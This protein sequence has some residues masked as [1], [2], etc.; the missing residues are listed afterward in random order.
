MAYTPTRFA[1][2][3]AIPS[4][5]TN[6]VTFVSP[7]IVKQMSFTNITGGTLSFSM[8]LVPSGAQ[9][10]NNSNKLF[11]DYSLPANST[12]NI[13]FS[14]VCNTGESLYAVANVPN[15]INVVISGITAA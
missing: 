12:T 15:S 8:Y 2:P 7:V 11:G 14:L 9:V 10:G 3:Q 4:V 1:G 6:L 13:T 5:P